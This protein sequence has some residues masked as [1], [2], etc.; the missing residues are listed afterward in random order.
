MAK[1]A[2]FIEDKMPQDDLLEQAKEFH[3]EALAEFTQAV[4]ARN[5]V[6][7]RDACEKGWNAIVLATN[8]LIFKKDGKETRSHWER[9]RALDSL[10]KRDPFIQ[11]KA[12]SDKFSARAY[13]LHQEAFYGGYLEEE[14]IRSELEKVEGY[15]K[16]VEEL[17]AR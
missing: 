2:N 7:L 11:E 1:A 8:Y 6:L 13:Y 15:I 17:V 12:M 16:A 3:Q 5:N 10:E 4:K 9:R 14:K